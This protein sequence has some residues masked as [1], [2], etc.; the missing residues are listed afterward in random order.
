LNEVARNEK[1]GF[2]LSHNSFFYINDIYL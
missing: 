1:C 2:Y